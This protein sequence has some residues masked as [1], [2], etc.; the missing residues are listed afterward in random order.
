MSEFKKV[1]VTVTVSAAFRAEPNPVLAEAAAV[2]DGLAI[3]RAIHKAL[4]KS[5]APGRLAIGDIH[6]FTEEVPL[7]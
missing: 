3:Q 2:A 6:V 1:K 4:M 5:T 7:V